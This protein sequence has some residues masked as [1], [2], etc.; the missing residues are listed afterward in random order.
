MRADALTFLWLLCLMQASDL[1]PLIHNPKFL[2]LTPASRTTYN[3]LQSL[4]VLNAITSARSGPDYLLH[5]LNRQSLLELL[6]NI[7]FASFWFMPSSSSFNLEEV[8]YNAREA[9]EKGR[10]SD[11][12]EKPFGDEDKQSLEETIQILEQ[13]QRDRGWRRLG[14]K[15]EASVPF[16]V[17]NVPKEIAGS[18][19]WLNDAEEDMGYSS[20]ALSPP[21][22]DVLPVLM[23]LASKINQLRSEAVRYLRTGHES[24]IV[25]AL[26]CMPTNATPV[27]SKVPTPTAPSLQTS[28]STLPSPALPS[29]DPSPS[30]SVFRKK[31]H[32]STVTH[33]SHSHGNVLTASKAAAHA[34]TS[35]MDEIFLPS[36]PLAPDSP[37]S[38]IVL[39]RTLSAKL[40]FI[41]QEV[42]G[43]IQDV[44][45]HACLSLHNTMT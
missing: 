4:I 21:P 44:K 14:G 13:A 1:P 15:E 27:L 43:S 2:P 34:S 9:R 31:H 29:L 22:E 12:G 28:I 35:A 32:R 6:A 8:L 11:P 23:V 5:P 17:K 16:M 20:S 10:P 39:Q 7:R 19:G 42:C 18:H 30:L 36:K 40:N 3:V 41:I 24:T 33:P 38:Q 37:L 25:E 26:T 45:I